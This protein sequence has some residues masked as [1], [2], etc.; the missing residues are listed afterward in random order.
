MKPFRFVHAADLHLDSPF[1]GLAS[2]TPEQ[3]SKSL[4]QATFDAYDNIVELCISEGVDALLIAGDVY[5]GADRSLRAQRWFIDGL[6][7]L[8]QAGIRSF[9]CHGNHDPLDGWEARLTYPPSCHRFGSEFQAVPIFE[10]DPAH[11]VVHGVSYPTRN[12][13]SNLIRRLGPVDSQSFN[14]GLLHANVDNDASHM[15]YA[16]CSLNDLAVTGIDYWALGHVHTRQVLN[17]QSP[18]AVYPGNP[19]G[20]HLNETGPRGAYL[21]SIDESGRPYLDFRSVDTIRWERISIDI[22][23]ADTEQNLLDELHQRVGESLEQA[24]GRSLV[25]RMTLAGHGGLHCF[26]CQPN[27]IADLLDDINQAWAQLDPFAWCERIEDR[28]APVFDRARRLQ[29][30]DFVADVLRL[31]DRAKQDPEL[32]HELREGLSELF[33]HRRYRR[34]LKDWIPD[35]AGLSILL[36]EAESMVMNLLVEDDGP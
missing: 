22:A 15:A 16:P 31:C 5:D 32:L 3:V 27:A 36:G 9:V 13:K 8:H 30:S 20:R 28:T 4:R 21:V 23:D 7:R 12:V 34:F 17:A 29:G 14:I 2:R 33:Q 19:Q 10:D 26:L 18:T 6:N 11:A 24:E 1:T 25:L 35:D